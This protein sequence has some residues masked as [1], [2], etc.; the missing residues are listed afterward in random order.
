MEPAGRIIAQGRDTDIVEHGPGLVLRRPR[1]PRSLATEARVMEWVRG[2]GYPCP[3][4]VELVDDG[5]VMQ[6]IEGSSML[7]HLGGHPWQLRAQATLLADLHGWLHRLVVPTELAD[8]LRH[9]F[10]DGRELLHLDLH[11]GNVMLTSDGPM[12][13]DWT[14]AAV[15]DGP[16]DVAVAWLLMAA[17]GVPGNLVDRALT[18]T[19]RPVLVHAFLAATDRTAASAWLGP[20]LEQRRLDPHLS[21]AELDA[22]A[23]IVQR[24]DRRSEPSP[25]H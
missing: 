14:N 15:G 20:A 2:Q 9:P 6:R 18:A 25:R 13:I 1:V 23:R 17:G 3:A 7:D 22:M 24:A 21:P 16:A 19:F 8:V 4:V 10:G 5:M 11:P 12:V